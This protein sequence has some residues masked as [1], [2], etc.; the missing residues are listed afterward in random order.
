MF[1]T[2]DH[3]QAGSPLLSAQRTFDWLQETSAA[4][5]TQ[6]RIS[7][8]GRQPP[9]RAPADVSRGSDP[10]QPARAEMSSQ[11]LAYLYTPLHA[12]SHFSI[13]AGDD[14]AFPAV[15]KEIRLGEMRVIH[16]G[17]QTEMFRDVGEGI[18]QPSR[19]C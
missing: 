16:V 13:A 7:R 19:R 11:R 3:C 6:H 18:Y 12:H 8:Q 4:H 17:N 5:P 2:E 9:P 1:T 14:N 10:R 15:L